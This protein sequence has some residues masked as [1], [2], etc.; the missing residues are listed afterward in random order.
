MDRKLKNTLILVGILIAIVVAGG[1]F[2]FVFQKGKI[3]DRKAVGGAICMICWHG[4]PEC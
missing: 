4:D 3:D 1:I 2:T